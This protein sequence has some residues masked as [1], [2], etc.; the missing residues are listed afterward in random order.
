MRILISI[1]NYGGK[2][3]SFITDTSEHNAIYKSYTEKI[4][5]FRSDQ[6][7]FKIKKNHN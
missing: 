5:L 6:I 7:R 2:M 1:L 4:L 3:A